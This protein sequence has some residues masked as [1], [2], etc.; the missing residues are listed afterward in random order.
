[1]LADLL[2]Y[3]TQQRS[4][5]CATYYK[6]PPPVAFWSL[7]PLEASADWKAAATL[8][9]LLTLL[10][11]AINTTAVDCWLQVDTPQPPEGAAS[12]ASYIG[13]PLPVI[14]YMCGWAKNNSVT[15]GK[16]IDPTMTPSPAAWRFFG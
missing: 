13:S 10:L 2:D 7:S 6:R 1:M 12:A 8:S 15:E 9:S 11:R 16:Y 4:A 3:Y 5:L 14:I